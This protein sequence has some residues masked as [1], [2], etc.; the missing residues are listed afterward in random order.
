MFIALLFCGSFYFT[1]NIQAVSNGLI[2]NE[3]VPKQIIWFPTI[4]IVCVF[5][6]LNIKLIRVNQLPTCKTEFWTER[7]EREHLW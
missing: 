3:P 2:L 4:Q 7:Q 5:F 6:I 1:N